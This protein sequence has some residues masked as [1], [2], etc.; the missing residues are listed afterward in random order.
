MH[1]ASRIAQS[2]WLHIVGNAEIK[3]D[4]EVTLE[5]LKNRNV[6]L[7]GNADE[8]RFSDL[9]LAQSLDLDVRN[10]F[11]KLGQEVY[12]MPGFGPSVL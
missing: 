5:D 6:A 1:L 3:W 8:N 9:V 10:K 7:I 4:D 12:N 11:I 2:C